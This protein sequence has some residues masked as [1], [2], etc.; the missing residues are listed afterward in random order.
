MDN[1]KSKKTYV[2]MNYKKIIYLGTA[3]SYHL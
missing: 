2:K 1:M 3:L